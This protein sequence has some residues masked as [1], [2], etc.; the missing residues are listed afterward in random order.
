MDRQEIHRQF[1]ALLDEFEK[2]RQYGY[3]QIDFVAGQADLIR[4]MI[5]KKIQ[6]EGNSRYEPRRET[7]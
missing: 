7:R 4:K 6:N 5:T 1:D 2:A 3:I